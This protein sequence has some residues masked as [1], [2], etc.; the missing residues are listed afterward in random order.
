M[1][2]F[3][4]GLAVAAAFALAGCGAGKYD[5]GYGKSADKPYSGTEPTQRPY[6]IAGKHYYPMASANGYVED[7]RASRITSYNVCYT[8]L[9]R[10]KP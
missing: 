3:I 2:A 6:S 7:G 8:K 5:T 1:P 4:F 10:G 9:L